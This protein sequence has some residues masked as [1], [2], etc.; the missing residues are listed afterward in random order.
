MGGLLAGVGCFAQAELIQEVTADKLNF[1]LVPVILEAK[2]I[3]SKEKEKYSQ[4]DLHMENII[5]PRKSISQAFQVSKKI[6]LTQDDVKDVQVVIDELSQFAINIEMTQQGKRKLEHFSRAFLGQ[7]TIVLDSNQGIYYTTPI[8]GHVLNQG[9]M[10]IGGERISY[11]DAQ[12]MA[13]NIRKRVEFRGLNDSGGINNDFELKNLHSLG[14]EPESSFSVWANIDNTIT[15]QDIDRVQIIAFP[16]ETSMG[17]AL[18]TEG[19][20]IP[21]QPYYSV[22]RLKPSGWRKAKSGQRLAFM[23]KENKFVSFLPI[24]NQ[25]SIH[26]EVFLGEQERENFLRKIMK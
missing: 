1:R 16:K 5:E 24:Q 7:R 22:L 23:N 25:G 4:I 9:D 2:D 14:G 19:L 13:E 20:G 21:E 17:F 8:M 18:P 11:R 6:Y 12:K 3:P 10:Q 26:L 15:S